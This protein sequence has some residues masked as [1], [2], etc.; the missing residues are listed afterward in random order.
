MQVYHKKQNQF[1]MKKI[2]FLVAIT[3]STLTTMAQVQRK[4]RFAKNNSDSTAALA[5]ADKGDRQGKR[6][7]LK[8]LNLTKEQ[9]GK[10]KAMNQANKAKKDEIQNDTKLNDTERQAKLQELRKQQLESTSNILTAEQ[11]EKMKAMRKAKKEEGKD[12]KQA[13]DYSVPM[14][15]EPQ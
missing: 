6:D 2:L 8:E 4:G 15:N 11:K 5:N 9:R 14:N 1:K 10:I 7:K 12:K 13:A 3:I